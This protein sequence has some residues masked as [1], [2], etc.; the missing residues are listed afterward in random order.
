M[1]GKQTISSRNSKNSTN[2][3]V[4]TARHRQGTPVINTNTKNPSDQQALNV[5]VVQNPN[6]LLMQQQV[7]AT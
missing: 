3:Q 7:S 4:T 5:Q 6:Q 2:N 1:L